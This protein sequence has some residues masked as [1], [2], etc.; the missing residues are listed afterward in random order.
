MAIQQIQNL[1]NVP[2]YHESVRHPLEAPPLTMRRTYFP[3]GFPVEI[4]TNSEEIFPHCERK[5]G[6]FE[7]RFDIEPIVAEI[8][9]IESDS[10]EC[11]PTP[12]YRF[13]GNTMM[14]IADPSN[15]CVADFPRGKTRMVISAAALRYPGYVRQVFLDCAAAC[16]IG[17]AYTT[18]IHAACV[19]SLGAGVL[20]CGDS[21]AGKSSLAYACARAGWE[22]VTDDTSYLMRGSNDGTIIGDC[23]KLRFRPSAVDI[24]PELAGLPVVPR[25]LGRPSIELATAQMVNIRR[26]E[27][28]RVEFVVF[29]NRRMPGAA[30]LV[31]MRADGAR[32]YM[33]QV[34]FGAPEMLSAQYADIDQLLSANVF[35][36]RYES[37]EWAVQRLRRLVREGC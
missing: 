23:H 33:R 27:S 21:G 14:M 28:T 24:F 5:W 32:Q 31:H 20:L 16:Q 25:I 29:L 30:E 17:T 13:L 12:T 19:A 34:L 6:A 22:Y 15:F 4:H 8:H 7:R 3:L 18:P 35:E 11:P 36:L 10:S 9:V 2:L 26:L 1:S 37:L